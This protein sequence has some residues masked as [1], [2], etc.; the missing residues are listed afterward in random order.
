MLMHDFFF[1]LFALL[2]EQLISFI[3]KAFVYIIFIT[4]APLVWHFIFLLLTT[5][6]CIYSDLFE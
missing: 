3:H 4:F 1:L 5:T 2:P 6:S